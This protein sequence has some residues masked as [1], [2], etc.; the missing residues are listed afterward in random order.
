MLDA[1]HGFRKKCSFETQLLLSANN[2]LKSIDNSTQT[3]AILLDFV[4]AF[5]K[6]AC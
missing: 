4:K 6:I 5:D 3:D 1:R 2:F